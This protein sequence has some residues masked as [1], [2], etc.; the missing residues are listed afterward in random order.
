MQS[1]RRLIEDV[2][3][4]LLHIEAGTAQVVPATDI[5]V[6][7]KAGEIAAHTGVHMEPCVV[8]RVLRQVGGDGQVVVG[9]RGVG[10]PL[11]VGRTGACGGADRDRDLR[12]IDAQDAVRAGGNGQCRCACVLRCCSKCR[13]DRQW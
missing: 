2:R 10:E 7:G 5:I 8:V 1:D 4:A 12:S 3:N 13:K 9:G 11:A 6:A